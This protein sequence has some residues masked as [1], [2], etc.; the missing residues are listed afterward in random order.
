MI[1]WISSLWARLRQAFHARPESTVDPEVREIFLSELDEVSATLADLLTVW[2]QQRANPAT[3]KEIRRGFHTL[4]GSG[5]AV[6]ANELGAFC[7]RIEK[8]VVNLLERPN[9]ASP[10][11]VASIE[12]AIGVLPACARALRSGSAMPAIVRG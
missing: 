5:L 10:E 2:R 8:L 1:S 3:L 12:G 11:V 9:A 6:G 4:K 7:G